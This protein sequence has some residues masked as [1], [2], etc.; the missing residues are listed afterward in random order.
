MLKA[1][2]WALSDVTKSSQSYCNIQGK[3]LEIMRSCIGIVQ[4]KKRTLA[5]GTVFEDIAKGTG[6]VA[7]KGQ[8]VRLCN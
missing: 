6:P 4:T 8:M 1:F 3:N 7:K 5:G 2:K